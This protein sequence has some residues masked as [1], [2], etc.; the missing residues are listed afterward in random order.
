MS[1]IDELRKVV[2]RKQAQVRGEEPV[3]PAADLFP[4]LD[5]EAFAALRADIER[6]GQRVPIAMYGGAVL[7]GR[8]RLRACRELGVEPMTVDVPLDV[9]PWVYVVSLNLRRRHLLPH[10][11]GRVYAKILEQRGVKRGQGRRNDK[12][13]S[14][15]VGEVA[16]DLG[17]PIST[18]ERHLAAAETYAQLE[19]ATKAAVDAGDITLDQAV[20]KPR[21]KAKAE[22][23]SG[24]SVDDPLYREPKK[25]AGKP[26]K[27]LELAKDDLIRK[28]RSVLE[29][30]PEGEI[31]ELRITIDLLVRS[32]E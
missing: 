18:F 11:A 12:A 32:Y 9:D 8:N 4:M 30:W 26:Y 19:P 2:V 21:K 10:Q 1:S 31:G 6:H 25:P 29:R 20:G 28:L 23:D 15:T 14:P 7:D 5:G 22:E 16:S 24:N 27:N 3:H 13:T 17:V